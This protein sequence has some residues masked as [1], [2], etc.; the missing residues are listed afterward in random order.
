VIVEGF[1]KIK[2]GEVVKPEA[3]N[4]NPSASPKQ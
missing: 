2:D 3:W 4:P 1:Q